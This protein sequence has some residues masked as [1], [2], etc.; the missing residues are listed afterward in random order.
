MRNDLIRWLTW[1]K[2][3]GRFFTS[4]SPRPSATHI[5]PDFL[6]PELSQALRSLPEVGLQHLD[7][8]W[9]RCHSQH[10][11]D[12]AAQPANFHGS[13]LVMLQHAEAGLESVC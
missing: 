7:P 9:L 12:F 3:I 10:V 8:T 5:H 1:A 6:H 11:F 4:E 13:I 2:P